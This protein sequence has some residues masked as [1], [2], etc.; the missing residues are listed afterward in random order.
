MLLMYGNTHHPHK[1]V[2]EC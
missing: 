1:I 2:Y